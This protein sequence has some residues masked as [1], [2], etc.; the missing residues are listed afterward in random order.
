MNRISTQVRSWASMR[1]SLLACSC[2][3]STNAIYSTSSSTLLSRRTLSSS[4]ACRSTPNNAPPYVY[5]S[6]PT[7]SLLRIGGED[8]DKFL[9]GLITN[10]VARLRSRPTH[11][12]YAG[13]LK[14]DGRALHDLFIYPSP[15]PSPSWTYLLDHPTEVS[16]SFRKYL[17]RHILRSKV[18][19]APTASTTEHVQVAW[20]PRKGEDAP[21][22]LEVEVDRLALEA[23]EW[24]QANKALRDPRDG[25]M[26]WRWVAEQVP[27]PKLF[28]QVT[29]PY[30]HLHRLLLGIPEGQ[31]DLAS[32]PLE[33]N[34]D[35]LGAI[36]FKKGC[37]VGQELTARTHHKGVVRKRQVPV[38]L[39]REG[40]DVPEELYPTYS[41]LKPYPELFPLPPPGSSLTPPSVIGTKAAPRHTGRLHSTLPIVTSSGSSFALG[42]ATIRMDKLSPDAQNGGVFVVKAELKEG[43][44]QG[45]G[46]GESEMEGERWFAK[47]FLE[48]GGWL[49]RGLRKERERK[50]GDE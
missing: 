50:G 15:T 3:T 32:L 35:F 41:T 11:A 37:Y 4:S 19:L 33:G 25:S 10:D 34:L 5:T 8:V 43:E 12:L 17:K 16:D 18:K 6:L 22:D 46:A 7:R 48:E 1:P 13:V 21:P 40:E 44:E 47:A 49:S 31:A 2:N 36:D 9:Q 42:L 29:P 26:G 23:E 30:H 28:Q 27:P 39:F 14:A 45:W 20:K 38:R 24:L